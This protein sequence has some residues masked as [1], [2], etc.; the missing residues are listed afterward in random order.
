[1]AAAA[2]VTVAANDEAPA[3]A[4]PAAIHALRAAPQ[5]ATGARIKYRSTPHAC[6]A[7][8]AVTALRGAFGVPGGGAGV[9]MSQRGSALL[10]FALSG[11]RPNP[12]ASGGRTDLNN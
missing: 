5:L 4:S 9:P 1:V 7:V 8:V 11:S 12:V 2:V 10:K 3:E 6:H